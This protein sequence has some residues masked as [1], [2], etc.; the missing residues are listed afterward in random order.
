VEVGSEPW[1]LAFNQS[2]D[3]LYVANSG[4]TNISVVSPSGMSEVSRI[5]TPNI[6]L[7]DVA[8]EPAQMPNP[9]AGA[10]GEPDSISGVFPTSVTRHDYSDRPQ[11]IGVTQNENLIYSTRPTDAAADGTVRIYR[12]EQARLEMVTQY[13][14]NRPGGKL[15][16]LN[17]DSAFLV[18]ADPNDLIDVC[19]RPRS[20]DPAID[21]TLPEACFF[22]EIGQVRD[23]LA[24]LGYDTEFHFNRDIEE[25]GLS[26]TTFVAVSGDHGTVAFGEGAQQNA[27]VMVLVDSAGAAP[28]DPLYKH[29]EISDLVGNTAERVIGLSLNSD[30]SLGVA[31]GAQAYFFS[32]DLRLQGVVATGAQAGG[33][34]MH[35]DSPDTPRSFVSGIEDNGLAYID[36]VDSFHFNRIARIFMRDPVT[37]PVRAVDTGSSLTIYAVTASGIAVV[38]V[39]TDDL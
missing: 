33:V 12:T 4:G 32:R 29:G 14:E 8:Y 15:V 38:E 19:P 11:F 27:R 30:G 34:D 13:A 3:R 36:V 24:A 25:I 21:G 28:N 9:D 26:D 23:T 5:Q 17:A 1:G 7:F 2:E 31:R 20:A 22:G 18:S 37:G 39:L 16:I 10:P 6:K 35:P